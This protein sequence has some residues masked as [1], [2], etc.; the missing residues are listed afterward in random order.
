MT[1]Q[2][3]RVRQR[4]GTN[5]P[6][7][8]HSISAQVTASEHA[9]LEEQCRLRGC[10]PSDLARGALGLDAMP[11]LRPLLVAAGQLIRVGKAHAIAAR[12][13]NWH[14]AAAHVDELNRY[15]RE[16]IRLA[17]EERRS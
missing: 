10:T 8:R 7:Q 14:A 12:G 3:R 13:G 6:R 2:R 17:A 9:R 16:L 15:A 4:D 1:E 11:P 5:S